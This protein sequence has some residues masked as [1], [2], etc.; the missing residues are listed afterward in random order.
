MNEENEIQVAGEGS[1][2]EDYE[3]SELRKRLNREVDALPDME[4]KIVKLFYTDG[5]SQKDIAS[6]LRL[7]RSKVNRVLGKAVIALKSRVS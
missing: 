6:K 4:K 5:M 2:A 7:S 3:F 1:P